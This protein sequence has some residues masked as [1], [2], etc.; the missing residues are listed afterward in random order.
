VK[1]VY[2]LAVIL[3][4]GIVAIIIIG[5]LFFPHVFYDQFIWK[6]LWGPIKADAVGHPVEWQGIW[7]KEGYTLVSEIIY[8]GLLV[9][10]LIGIYKLFKILKVTITTSFFIALFPF[11]V[12]GPVARVL[13]DS[14]LYSPPLV[15]WFISP[16]I[17]IQIAILFFG[18]FFFSFFLD[19]SCM[20][21]KLKFIYFTG[22]LIFI[23]L[24][25]ALAYLL[26]ENYCQYFV[27]PVSIMLFSFVPLI[28]VAYFLKREK[29]TFH[30]PLFSLGLLYLFPAVYL[31]GRWIIKDALY[32]LR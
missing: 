27:S 13:E 5:L 29:F 22:G 31:T 14:G 23:N 21:K 12:L 17:Y 18:S 4:L 2:R 6:Y 8:G 10:A 28:I 26:W 1:R 25:Y 7:V 30:I 32:I 16:V 24:F 20:S 9:L 3:G 15:Y 19:R 11:I